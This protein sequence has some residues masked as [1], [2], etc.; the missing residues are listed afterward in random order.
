MNSEERH[1][2]ECGTK[3][4]GRAD[5][6]FCSDACRNTYNNRQ[7]SDANNYVRNV[8]NAL[9]KNRRVLNTLCPDE[10]IKVKR[11]LL[12]QKGFSF[13]FF[14][15]T[16]QTKAGDVYYFCYE[17]GYLPLESEEVLIVRRDNQ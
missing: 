10:K 6:K 15:N 7:N 3:L 1:C 16:Y 13:Q 8:N 2:L 12:T 5:Q 4:F 17:M 14:T 11:S 9:R